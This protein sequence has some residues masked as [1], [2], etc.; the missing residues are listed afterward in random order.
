M[1]SCSSNLPDSRLRDLSAA[2]MLLKKDKSRIVLLPFLFLLRL[3][4]FTIKW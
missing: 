2:N 1:F 4:Y 3:F